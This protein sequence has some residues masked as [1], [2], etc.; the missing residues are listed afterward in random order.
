MPVIGWLGIAS[1]AFFPVAIAAFREVLR[2]GSRFL[3][4]V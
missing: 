3:F 4:S 1:G 2:G